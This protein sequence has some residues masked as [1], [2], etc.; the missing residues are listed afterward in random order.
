MLKI[1]EPRYFYY[2]AKTFIKRKNIMFKKLHGESKG[3]RFGD[4]S[5]FIE[6]YSSTMKQNASKNILMLIKQAFLLKTWV[7]NRTFC[8]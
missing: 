3:A 4:L 7:T 2:F 6:Q 8:T 5:E 1:V